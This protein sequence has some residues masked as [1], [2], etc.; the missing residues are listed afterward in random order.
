MAFLAAVFAFL[1]AAFVFM[2]AIFAFLATMFMFLAAMFAFEAAVFETVELVLL[3]AAF[4]LLIVAVG[5]LVGDAAG[6]FATFVLSEPEQPKPRVANA[7]KAEQAR[8][9]RI[10]FLSPVI[11]LWCFQ[12]VQILRE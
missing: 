9:L 10:E 4:E 6:V 12:A 5:V 8:I 3:A 11:T 1:A 7:S 2:A